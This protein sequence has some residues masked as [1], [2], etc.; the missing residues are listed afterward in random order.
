M[1]DVPNPQSPL[2]RCAFTRRPLPRE[3][4]PGVSL[5]E[6]AFCGHFNLRGDPRSADFCGAVETVLGMKLPMQPNTVMRGDEVTALWLGPDEWLVVVP[7]PR[8]PATG[9]A[10]RA[11]LEDGLGAVNDVSGGQTIIAIAGP[12]SVDV[13]SKGCTVDLDPSV[14]GP[15]QCAQTQLAKATAVIRPLASNLPAFDI[16]VRRSFAEYLWRWLEDASAEYGL[17]VL[18]PRHAE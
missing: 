11:A 7:P 6:V 16:V 12:N 13:L 3:G 14:F 15:G 8:A 1:S 2:G 18:A 10:L 5:H 4:E 17:T 9:S